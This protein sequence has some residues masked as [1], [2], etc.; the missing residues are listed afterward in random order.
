MWESREE[1][2]GG[3][4]GGPRMLWLWRGPVFL[5]QALCT[6]VRLKFRVC[7]IQDR[8]LFWDLQENI[9][10]TVLCQ[11]SSNKKKSSSLVSASKTDGRPL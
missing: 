1:R 10:G 2:M 9:K 6:V 3:G 5:C 4:I 7:G 8:Q 11:V